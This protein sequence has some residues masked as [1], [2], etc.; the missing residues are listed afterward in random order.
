VSNL[1][2]VADAGN[3]VV[4]RFDGTGRLLGMIG[5]RGGSGPEPR[6]IVPSPSLDLAVA[7]DA[8]LWAVNP[9]RLRLEQFTLDGEPLSSW[10]KASMKIDGFCGCCNPTHI[11]VDAK[12][13][14]FTS[15][16][17]IPRV[18]LYDPDGSFVGVVAPPA[19]FEED[20]VGLDLA[21]DAEGRLLVLDPAAGAIRVFVPRTT[22]PAAEQP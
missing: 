4:W 19:Q 14:F 7:P 16:K 13:R 22:D 8:T 11:A 20:A 17:G 18:K 1:V 10:G 6:F 12:G 9:G 15:E 21:V 5:R 2:F 3:R